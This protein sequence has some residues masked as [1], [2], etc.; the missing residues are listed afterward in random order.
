MTSTEKITASEEVEIDESNIEETNTEEVSEIIEQFE[1]LEAFPNY[2]ISHPSFHIKNNRTGRILKP[3]ISSAGYFRYTLYKD[4]KKYPIDLHRIIAIHFLGFNPDNSEGLEIDH[5]NRDITDNTVEN[6]RI[7]THSENNKNRAKF[8]KS[9][10]EF[11]N[12]LPVG[13]QY[14]VITVAGDEISDCYIKIEDEIYKKFSE[15]K[16]LHLTKDKRNRVSIKGVN[17]T[18]Y[19][20]V[21]SKQLVVEKID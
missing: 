13:E 21:N 12:E 20:T 15:N 2:S 11:I 1:V 3:S 10:L 16:Y 5:I 14:R 7:V 19:I 4:R 9:T 18:H 6:L 17:R 8:T